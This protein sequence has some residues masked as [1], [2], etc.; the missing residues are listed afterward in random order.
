MNHNVIKVVKEICFDCEGGK[1]TILRICNDCNGIRHITKWS[2]E[3]HR[4]C[5][6][7]GSHSFSPSI[8]KQAQFDKW[9]KKREEVFEWEKL[10]EMHH[11]DGGGRP[12]EIRIDSCLEMLEDY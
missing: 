1:Q 5:W 7:C 12:R 10:K 6:S 8:D 9:L 4:K 11:R 3:V 2:H